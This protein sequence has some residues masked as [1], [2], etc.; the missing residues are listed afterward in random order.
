MRPFLI[1]VGV[2]KSGTTL[3]HRLLL[4]QGVARSI[5]RSEGN[6]FWGNE[7]PFSPEGEPL[8]TIYQRSAGEQ[9]H[10]AGDGDATGAVRALL[11]QR[12]VALD[13][14]ADP[15]V[16]KNPYLT[17]SLP[18]VRALFPDAVIVAMVR[19]PLAN[20]FSLSKKHVPHSGRGLAPEEGWWGGKPA[21]WRELV[22]DDRRIQCALQWDAVNRRLL[23]HADQVDRVIA[24]DALCAAP[25]E[26]L[27]DL[28]LRLHG[29][30]KPVLSVE[31][32]R[33]LDDEF[34]TGSALRS[35]NRYYKSVGSL[36]IPAGEAVELAP[37]TEAQGAEVE[38]ICAATWERL[39]VLSG[40]G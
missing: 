6:D 14:G 39:R 35:K 15:I 37:W 25:T 7:P 12:L 30:E 32:L 19:Q 3:L 8:G 20:V 9:G 40:S 17:L 11:E 16:N 36:E 34:S 10:E 5:F 31:P 29:E 27:R 24:Y 2:Q 26:T 21:G 1:I 22:R 18:W 38:A 13:S 23:E 33:C 4:E 28:H